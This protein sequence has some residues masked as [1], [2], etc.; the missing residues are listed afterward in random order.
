MH[1]DEYIDDIDTDEYASFF[2]FLHRLPALLQSKFAKRIAELKL[3]CTYKGKRY[4]VTGASRLG[5]IWLS[6]EHERAV[7][8]DRR[9]DIDECCFFSSTPEVKQ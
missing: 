5:D 4:R 6:V 9:V 3:F 7:G 1:V 2:L 8:Y